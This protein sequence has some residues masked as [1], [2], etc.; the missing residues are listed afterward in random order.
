MTCCGNRGIEVG[1]VL[2]GRKQV[3]R[4]RFLL[5]AHARSS[6]LRFRD[7][8]NGSQGFDMEGFAL[9]ESAAESIPRFRDTRNQGGVMKGFLGSFLRRQEDR[10]EQPAGRES[11]PPKEAG[12]SNGPGATE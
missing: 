7:S 11:L 12:A 10:V 6:G 1:K 9:A 2:V 8:R 5:R 3:I 4:D